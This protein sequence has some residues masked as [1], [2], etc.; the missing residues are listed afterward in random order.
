MPLLTGLLVSCAPRDA[1]PL[2][3]TVQK[4]KT[5]TKKATA[6]AYISTVIKTVTLLKNPAARMARLRRR[7]EEERERQIS[8]RNLCPI[9]PRGIAIAAF[10]NT[11]SMNT[12]EH[13]MACCAPRKTVTSTRVILKTLTKGNA[14][15]ATV[16][17]RKTTT[18]TQYV[19]KVRQQI[20]GTL[21]TD[22]NNNGAYDIRGDVLL[23][24]QVLSIYILNPNVA[25]SKP[26]A[27]FTVTTDAS[28]HF[29]ITADLLPGNLIVIAPPG[30][31]TSP[32]FRGVVG[33]NG[34]VLHSSDLCRV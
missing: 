20:A 17:L 3:S 18:S 2:T 19:T 15:I 1:V 7:R 25:N 30:Q 13:A 22:A 31:M 23:A 10:S 8:E 34:W 6:T 32:W 16:T 4:T 27:V 21:F 29:S 33:K 5:T 26:L 11:G 14:Q 9:C 24:N 28:G 12:N